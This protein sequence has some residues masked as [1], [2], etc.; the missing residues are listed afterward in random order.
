MFLLRVIFLEPDFK[1]VKRKLK[2]LK[3]KLEYYSSFV[4]THGV[5]EMSLIIPE[6]IMAAGT[7][8]STRVQLYTR[9]KILFVSRSAQYGKIR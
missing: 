3:K 7:Q 4:L 2:L 6:I 9:N 1:E 5:K 8:N